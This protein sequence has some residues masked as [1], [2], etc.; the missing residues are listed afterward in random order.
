MNPKGLKPTI[1]SNF[2]KP[3]IVHD[4]VNESMTI[5]RSERKYD[6]HTISFRCSREL[7]KIEIKQYLAK[8][9]ELPILKLRTRN[10]MGR[11]VKIQSRA[12]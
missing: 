1:T 12:G 3:P 8:L 5:Q 11:L 6:H 9:Y 4:F 7:S 10:K 2:P